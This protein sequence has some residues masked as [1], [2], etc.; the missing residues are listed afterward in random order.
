MFSSGLFIFHSRGYI[1][2]HHW[3]FMVPIFTESIRFEEMGPVI[4]NADGTTRRIDNWDQMTKNEQEVAWRR[5]AKRNEERRKAL[6]EE[7]QKQQQNEQELDEK[8]GWDMRYRTV[9]GWHDYFLLSN[10]HFVKCEI[11]FKRWCISILLSSHATT[12]TTNASLAK[13]KQSIKRKRRVESSQFSRS[14]IDMRFGCFF[15][16]YSK[17]SYFR[18]P[19]STATLVYY[20]IYHTSL[21][22]WVSKWG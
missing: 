13:P 16:K 9:V 6:L 2:P 19:S 20:D 1:P 18:I 4:I 11:V 15:N 7:Q 14:Q 10:H 5:I 22:C 21:A 8:E 3:K 12:D 17:W